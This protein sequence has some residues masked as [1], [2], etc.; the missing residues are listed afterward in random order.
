MEQCKK[1]RF[2]SSLIIFGVC[3]RGG[4]CSET[5]SQP[6]LSTSVWPF[7]HLCEE[8]ALLVYRS[9]SEVIVSYVAFTTFIEGGDLRMF[10]WQQLEPY[11][12]KLDV[13]ESPVHKEST[14]NAGDSSSIPGWERSAGEGLD[15]PLL[16]S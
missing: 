6:V 13:P 10:P 16:Y 11:S 7:S 5:V 8:G 2:V 12:L 4:V 1:L 9:F 15:Y 3:T 14:S